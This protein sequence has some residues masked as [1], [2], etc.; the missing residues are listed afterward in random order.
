MAP[1][2]ISWRHQLGEARTSL[3]RCMLK[4]S[5]TI[6]IMVAL[7]TTEIQARMEPAWNSTGEDW[8]LSRS[9]DKLSYGDSHQLISLS[10]PFPVLNTS[11]VGQWNCQSTIGI[12]N[13][14][15]IEQYVRFYMGEGRS[16]FEETLKRARPYAPIMAEILEDQGVPAE[17]LSIPLV[18]S[19]FKR[20]ATY[21]GAGGYWQLLA[22]TA[23]SM[24]LRVDRWV[25]ER[26]DPI[27]STQAA[28]RY[29]RSF[30][31]QFDSWPLALAAYNAGEGPVERALSRAGTSDFWEISRRKLLPRHTRTY[32]PKVL[33]AVRIMRDLEAHGFK[34]QQ[35]HPIYDFESIWV[36][37]PL[38]LEQVAKWVGVSVD[39]MQD[40]NPSLRRDR[41]PPECGYNLHLPS[42]A[43]DRFDIA[44]KQYLRN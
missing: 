2:S 18:E 37:S 43:R 36:K 15:A 25:D 24:G 20:N 5:L 42:G 14:P 26:R 8:S 23:R 6:F 3:Q 19:C 40:L 1:F 41:L 7:S 44:Y 31:D 38:R 34:Q 27:K 13:Q 10:P 35:P 17:M 22:G 16:T 11:P 33:A 30:Y 4:A 12:P 29:L 39:F 32:V 9:L 21:R 28:A